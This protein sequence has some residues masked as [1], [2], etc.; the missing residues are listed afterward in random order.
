[1]FA[2]IRHITF[3]DCTPA[4]VLERISLSPLESLGFAL[5]TT[6]WQCGSTIS[7]TSLVSFA[8]QFAEEPSLKKRVVFGKSLSLVY[9]W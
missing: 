5:T 3:R 6:E 4:L 2:P 1:M 8:L 7:T 9:W